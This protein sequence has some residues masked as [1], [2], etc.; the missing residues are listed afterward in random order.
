MAIWSLESTTSEMPVEKRE[1]WH[2]SCRLKFG[3]ERL[4]RTRKRVRLDDKDED[5][6]VLR[7]IKRHAHRI[8]TCIFAE[9]ETFMSIQHWE[10]IAMCV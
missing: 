2:K 3:S 6:P 4:E 10:Q 9:E 1:P 7:R 8:E 5:S